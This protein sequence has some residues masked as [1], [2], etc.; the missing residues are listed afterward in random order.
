[1]TISTLP[2]L[3]DVNRDIKLPFILHT[4]PI[5]VLFW[6]EDFVASGALD[7]INDVRLPDWRDKPRTVNYRG[8]F[9]ITGQIGH[10]MQWAARDVETTN[11]FNYLKSKYGLK[12]GDYIQI[13]NSIPTLR[14]LG[15]VKSIAAT[16]SENKAKA[17]AAE[18]V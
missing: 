7:D 9:I 11:L 18:I 17:L 1:M 15:E 5:E 14:R 4:F 10:S 16:I 8:T 12:D 2:P 6:D 3:A 13:T